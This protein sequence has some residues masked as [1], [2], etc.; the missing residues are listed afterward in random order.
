[1]SQHPLPQSPSRHARRSFAILC[2]FAA[3][4]AFAGWLAS[5]GKHAVA[6]DPAPPAGL[7]DVILARAALAALD[8]DAELKGIARR[9]EE[10]YPQIRRGW[11]YRLVW[12]RRQLMLLRRR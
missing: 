7:S 10:E 4:V 5:G 1:M 9:L 3:G 6:A 8:A 12:L 2:T 11:S